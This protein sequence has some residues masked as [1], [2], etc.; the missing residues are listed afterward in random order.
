[1]SPG[2]R[3]KRVSSTRMPTENPPRFVPP[4]SLMKRRCGSVEP[5]ELIADAPELAPHLL[6]IGRVGE[7]AQVSLPA[8][9][10]SGH[11]PLLAPR[12]PAVPP[13]ARRRRVQREQ[14]VDDRDH[15]VPGLTAPVAALE[16][17]QH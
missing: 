4:W 9:Q 17:H 11:V 10:A 14:A 3:G 8:G 16:I 1:M 6:A 5:G 12:D 2:A 15:P 7:V 13:L